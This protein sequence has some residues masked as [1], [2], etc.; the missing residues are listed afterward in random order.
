MDALLIIILPRVVTRAV[1]SLRSDTGSLWLVRGQ[2]H[3]LLLTFA[4]D[5]RG[6]WPE[7]LNLP[8]SAKAVSGARTTV[9][10]DPQYVLTHNLILPESV[11]R[12]LDQVI[13]LQLERECPIP[14]ER[15]CFDKT[16]TG[17]L[18]P[19]RQLQ[20]QVLIAHRQRV[21]QA[22]RIVS[23]W[24]LNVTRVGMGTTPEQVTGNFLRKRAQTT[25]L[26][27]TRTQRRLSVSAAALAVL[28]LC[29]VAIHWT[30]ERIQVG[31]EIE[32]L[33]APAET[34]ARLAH[35]LQARA[36]P[37]EALVRLMSQPDAAD[38][39]TRLTTE[40]PKDA[41]VYDL[42]VTAQWPQPAHIKL[43]G[44]APVA[45]MLIGH[46]ENDGQ[47]QRVRLVSALSAGLGSGLD[48]IQITAQLATPHVNSVD[49]DNTGANMSGSRSVPGSNQQD[50]LR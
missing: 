40:I 4:A 45:T 30:Y 10:L 41:W 18:K 29:I 13:T 28:W 22:R 20:V 19:E 32:R 15:A 34:A 5:P 7:S 42:E 6:S 35:D 16:I 31:H 12:N 48:R 49:T 50:E 23:G 44:F 25:R 27:W 37:G 39:L 9:L 1:V 21:E 46:L 17:R 2:K 11:E 43:S 33:R 36:Q 8:E 24:G 26:E 14:P 3:E 47:F 38:T